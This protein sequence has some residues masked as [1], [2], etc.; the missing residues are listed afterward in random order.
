MRRLG[1]IA[2]ALL[3]LASLALADQDEDRSAW[4]YR[5]LVMPAAT[6]APNALFAALLLDPHVLARCQ[7][8]LRDVRLVTPDGTEVPW[9]LDRLEAKAPPTFAARLMTA[10]VDQRVRSV[11]VLDFGAPRTFDRVEL[12]VDARDFTKSLRVES[13]DDAQAWRVLREDAGIFDKEFEGRVHHTH[14]TFSPAVTARYLR[15]TADDRTSPRIEVRRATASVS[16]PKEARRWKESVTLE[17]LESPKGRSRFRLTAGRALPIEAV[18]IGA[19][20]PVFSRVVRLVE[21]AEAPATG[22]RVLG[23]ARLYRVH[24]D[25]AVVPVEGLGFDVSRPGSGGLVLEIENGDSPPLKGVTVEVAGVSERLLFLQRT[26]P[27][28]LYYGNRVT[29]AP[30][31][32]LAAL[33]EHIVSQDQLATVEVGPE[34]EN[35]RYQG[36]PP[37]QFVARAGAPIDVRGWHTVRRV[38]ITGSEDLYSLTLAA[39]DLGHL[40]PDFRDLR[41]ADSADHQVP[42]L[43]EAAVGEAKV[44]VQHLPMASTEPRLSRYTL[45][46]PADDGRPLSLP[47]AALE[48]AVDERYF[49]RNFRLTV[50][51][52]RERQGE[53]TLYAG[54]LVRPA[55]ETAPLRI[56]LEGIRVAEMNLRIDEGDDAHLTLRRVSAIVIVPRVA[57][58]AAK[59]TYRLLL[60]NDRADAPR[61]DIAGLRHDLLAYSA[62][63]AQA[64]SSEANVS[65]RRS[66]E[67]YLCHAPPTLMLWGTLVGAVVAL[68]LLTTRI[69]KSPP[70][71]PAD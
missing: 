19:G 54:L 55:G 48:F 27:W 11:W 35:A 63:P 14:V 68:L 41:I 60:D 20:D 10:R 18:T 50:P 5:R 30:S 58:K 15:M 21:E 36:V 51:S 31:Y 39:A 47:I 34:N 4:R 70:A 44:P 23:E 38:E 25:A 28:T 61:Y 29:R 43:L 52:R 40:R 7:A 65:Y 66:T 17:A 33:R 45:T 64:L 8:D 59:G 6:A 62:L 26:G 56:P 57:F 46:L 16:S 42:Y 3:T 37:L 69:L 2:V 49:S 13:S 32:D 24:L 9:I 1:A 53:R 22:S 71:P 12:E 67:A